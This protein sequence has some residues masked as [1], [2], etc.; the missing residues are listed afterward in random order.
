[1]RFHI[2]Q[3]GIGIDDEQA[4]VAERRHIA[5]HVWL[6]RAFGGACQYGENKGRSFAFDALNVHVAAHQ[7]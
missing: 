7:L 5:L 3:V 2:A 4:L 6:L 1:M